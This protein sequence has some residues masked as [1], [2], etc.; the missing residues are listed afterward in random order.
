M[1]YMPAWRIFLLPS[2]PPLSHAGFFLTP[3]LPPLL[4]SGGV[5]HAESRLH[6]DGVC[7]GWRPV[8]LRAVGRKPAGTRCQVRRGVREHQ[9]CLKEH[10]I[11][12]FEILNSLAP[13]TIWLRA[14][15]SSVSLGP[16]WLR[17]HCDSGTSIAPGPVC[18]WDVCLWDQSGSRTRVA[19][20]FLL[21]EV[22]SVTA[23]QVVLPTYCPWAGLHPPKRS[24]QQVT[25]D[26]ECK[27]TVTHV[28]PC[29]HRLSHDE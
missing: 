8:Q 12:V 16:V 17:D 21:M 7:L 24:H 4:P 2:V 13:G 5:P 26:P 19:A 29:A 18:H 25:T 27:R 22:F 15:C 6:G 20:G 9:H 11:C 10:R 1:I 28:F 23:S 14:R 3:S